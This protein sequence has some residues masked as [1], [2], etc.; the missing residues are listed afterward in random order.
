MATFSHICTTALAASLIF[1]GTVA[2]THAEEKPAAPA[3]AAATPKIGDKA[4]AFSLETLD[5]KNVELAKLVSEG[6]VVLVVL[7]GWPG[8][9]CP[10][11]TTQVGELI[12]KGDDFMAAKAR[13]VL[14]YPG[15]AEK[16]GEHAKEFAKGK[17]FKANFTFLT[18]PGF[19][20]TNAYGLRWDKA[21]ET[22]YPSA[23]VID[24]AGVV[25]F[26]K[27]SKSHGDRAAAND[28]LK[29]LAELK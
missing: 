29:A 12:N 27:V 3:P 1:G 17:N 26:A 2:M 9:Q 28:L 5:G 19:K 13:I 14:V 7:R 22:A 25:R 24:T 6:P 4:P 8:Y 10:V 21:G 16:L 11:C 20:L 15:P 18:D 23:F